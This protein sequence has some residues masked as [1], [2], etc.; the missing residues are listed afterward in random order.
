MTVLNDFGCD[1][2]CIKTGTVYF[3]PDLEKTYNEYLAG[4]NQDTFDDEEALIWAHTDIVIFGMIPTAKDYLEQK[5]K[6]FIQKM[7]Q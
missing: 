3:S 1:W 2:G 5:L 4:Q 6:K 7:A